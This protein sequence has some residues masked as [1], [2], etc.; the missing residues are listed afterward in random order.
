MG[1]T[2]KYWIVAN[3]G[4][5]IWIVVLFIGVLNVDFGEVKSLLHEQQ[6]NDPESQSKQ[7][8]IMFWGTT[9]IFGCAFCLPT[10]KMG[11]SISRYILFCFLMFYSLYFG[12]NTEAN[13]VEME[14][15]K[16]LVIRIIW[17]GFVCSHL[18]ALLLAVYTYRN[19]DEV[20]SRRMLYRNS[21]V[22]MFE[23]QMKYTI[24]RLMDH[25]LAFYFLYLVILMRLFYSFIQL[26]YVE[27]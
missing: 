4:L 1:S 27:N 14:A 11:S 24:C 6:T 8:E 3:L 9:L 26:G 13:S 15:G 7:I 20:V 5:I 25:A 12:E 23:E 2:I 16:S 19:F 18:L 17:I 10:K 22:D 21:A